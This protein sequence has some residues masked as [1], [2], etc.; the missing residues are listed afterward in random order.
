[1]VRPYL[2]SGR[3]SSETQKDFAWLCL[4]WNRHR[5]TRGGSVSSGVAVWHL[6]ARLGFTFVPLLPEARYGDKALGTWYGAL[7]YVLTG[8]PEELG[9]CKYQMRLVFLETVYLKTRC[10]VHKAW[11]RACV[12]QLLLQRCGHPPCSWFA[13][14]CSDSLPCTGLWEKLWIPSR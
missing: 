10:C 9:F 11:W 14:A 6:G 3:A 4:G 5:V 8:S 2:Q 12:G 1:M 13:L 7:G